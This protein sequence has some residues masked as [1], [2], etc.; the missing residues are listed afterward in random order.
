MTPLNWSV[1]KPV[2][3]G[4]SRETARRIGAF[5]RSELTPPSEEERI[6]QAFYGRIAIQVEYMATIGDRLPGTSGPDAVA[7]LLGKV[8]DAITFAPTRRRYPAIAMRLPYAFATS[9]GR[10]GRLAARTDAWWREQ[11]PRFGELDLDRSIRTFTEGRERFDEAMHTHV[12]GLLSTVQPLYDGAHQAGRARRRRRRGAAERHR[13]SRDGD[14]RG[15]LGRG[16]RA[17]R[18]RAGDPKPRLPRAPGGRAQLPRLAR[19]SRAA[20]ADDR[21]VRRA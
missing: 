17:H 1:W 19:G 12:I 11:V 15:H 9:P 20:A 5:T 8:P 13:G 10:I 16:A 6:V 3:D 7:G 4:M 21:R 14:R 18:A 2:G